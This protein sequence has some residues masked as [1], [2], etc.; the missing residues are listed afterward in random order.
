MEGLM[1]I[2]R[3]TNQDIRQML[4]LVRRQGIFKYAVAEVMGISEVTFSRHL[5]REMCPEMKQ[6][7]KDAVDK[8][9]TE[10]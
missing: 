4:D 9:K 8:L 5:R 6:K 7:I 1:C 2:R 10:E 3:I